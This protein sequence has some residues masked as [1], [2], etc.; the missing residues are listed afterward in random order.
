MIAIIHAEARNSNV[1]N[2][3]RSI[4]IGGVAAEAGSLIDK[5]CLDIGRGP[6]VDPWNVVECYDK[7]SPSFT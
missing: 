7:L 1:S 4:K 2:K 6:V 5:V 3:Q